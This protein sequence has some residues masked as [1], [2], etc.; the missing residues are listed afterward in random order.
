MLDW[1]SVYRKLLIGCVRL[2]ASIDFI[3][4]FNICWRYNID[5]VL[6]NTRILASENYF[7]I[8]YYRCSLLIL[9]NELYIN[10]VGF[11]RRAYTTRAS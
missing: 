7:P 9:N 6:I 4:E 8:Q 11:G 5:K 2:R 1:F 10:V 3:I